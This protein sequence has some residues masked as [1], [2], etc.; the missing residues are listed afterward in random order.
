MGAAGGLCRGGESGKTSY[1]LFTLKKE[2][3]T[4]LD[5]KG[6]GGGRALYPQKRIMAAQGRGRKMRGDTQSWGGGK[7]SGFGRRER[8]VMIKYKHDKAICPPGG[9]FVACLEGGP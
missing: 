3:R 6:V 8:R 9:Q 4:G 5:Q 1:Q 2:R 7:R